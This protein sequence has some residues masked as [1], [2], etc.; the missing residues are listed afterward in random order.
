LTLENPET[1]LAE[2]IMGSDRASLAGK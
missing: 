1:L 2:E